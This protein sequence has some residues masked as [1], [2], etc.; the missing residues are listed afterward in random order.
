MNAGAEPCAACGAD[1][2]R[3]TRVTLRYGE[4]VECPACGSGL[5]QPRPT[6]ADLGSLHGADDY[7]NH[8]YFEA[9]RELTDAMRESCEAKLSRLEASVGPLSG[10]TMVDVGCDLGVMVAYAA[11]SRGMTALGIDIIPKVV[12]I[13]RAAGRDLRLGTLESVALPDASADLISGFDL[14]EHVDDPRRFA[15]EALR[16]LKPG[17]VL[18]LETPNFGGLIYRLGMALA[19]VPGLSKAIRPLQ[20]RLWPPFHVQYFTQASLG[21]LLRE[22]GFANVDVRGRELEAS[23]L[24]VS[25]ALR[26]AVRS[27]FAVASLARAPTLLTAVARKPLEDAA[28]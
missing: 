18:A 27:V 11:E 8:P 5:L 4:I 13:G 9:R 28:P 17:G 12:E 16:V 25:G 21:A 7:F 26:L 10:A 3:P 15:R 14:I 19:A 23:E 1:G 2:A 20:E 22:E 24:A 6:A